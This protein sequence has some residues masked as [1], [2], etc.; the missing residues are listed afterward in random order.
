MSAETYKALDQAIRNHV[1]AMDPGAIVIEWIAPTVAILPDQESGATTHFN[2]T[3]GL[4]L[5][6][7]IGLLAYHLRAAE[8]QIGNEDE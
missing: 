6:N 7:R 5:H 2:L 8:N 4:P 1:Q 3:S